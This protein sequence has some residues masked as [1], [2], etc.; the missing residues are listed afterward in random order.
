MGG[1]AAGWCQGLTLA[2]KRWAEIE[3]SLNRISGD[4]PALSAR[5]IKT[6]GLLSIFGQR[7][8]R[9]EREMVCFALEDGDTSRDEIRETVDELEKRSIICYRK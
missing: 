2:G 9:A 3:Q 4:L 8:L 5:V 7:E 6:V 1:A